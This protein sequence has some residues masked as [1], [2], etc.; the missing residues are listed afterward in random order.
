MIRVVLIDD[1]RLLRQG[2]AALLAADADIEVIA[3]GGD[4]ETA[5]RL[6]RELLPDVLLLDIRL[7]DIS[8]VKIARTLRQEMPDLKIIILSAYHYE[9][10]VRALFA[11][12]VDGYL[13]K[14]A[15][16]QELVA[17]VYGV[18]RGENVLSNE[19][20]AHLMQK[21]IRAGIAANETLSDRE[22]ETLQL[23]GQGQSNKDIATQLGI[24]VRTVETHVSNA[25]AKLGAHSRTEAVKLA[26]Q[27]GIIVIE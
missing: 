9:E 25:M 3:E 6:V 5:L 12:G 11:I 21:T 26:M 18:C 15:S 17:A 24:G 7:P 10:Y 23:V 8:G 20:S 1:H 4:G 22:R 13:L 2:T 16:G 14:N 19:V 27:R